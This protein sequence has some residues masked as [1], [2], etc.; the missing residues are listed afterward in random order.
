MG[1]QLSK[2][3]EENVSP[4]MK[5]G[6][7]NMSFQL[8]GNSGDISNSSS[9]PKNKLQ[10]QIGRRNIL[11]GVQMGTKHIKPLKEHESS[12]LGAEATKG[13][14]EIKS[15][16]EAGNASI[17]SLYG[18][19]D[20]PFLSEHQNLKTACFQ[21]RRNSILVVCFVQKFDPKKFYLIKTVLD[22]RTWMVKSNQHTRWNLNQIDLE[23]VQC[24]P[25]NDSLL[26]YLPA[27]R[28]YESGSEA[29]TQRISSQYRLVNQNLTVKDSLKTIFDYKEGKIDDLNVRQIITVEQNIGEEVLLHS[30]FIN[31]E[32]KFTV[33]NGR[34]IQNSTLE[35]SFMNTK[36]VCI[37]TSHSQKD[38]TT[39][40]K[41]PKAQSVYLNL[42]LHTFN[43]DLEVGMVVDLGIMDINEIKLIDYVSSKTAYF[44]KDR[45][46]S[47]PWFSLT[48]GHSPQKS[49]AIN[50]FDEKDN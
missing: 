22:G 48:Q 46:R 50:L 15:I 4:L 2:E 24:C 13:Q 45:R 1:C 42:K 19:A 36:G 39:P 47:M 11:E 49:L 44:F 12:H 35:R 27:E 32:M 25:I 41:E 43:L 5:E 38:K 10:G 34:K 16:A 26:V 9:P 30:W 28:V 18:L 37:L 40:K 3:T 29:Q 20:E 23:G 14:D 8:A 21:R 33:L 6:A 7:L 31:H 17:G